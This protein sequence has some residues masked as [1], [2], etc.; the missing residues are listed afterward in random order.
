MQSKEIDCAQFFFYLGKCIV[1]L[2]VAKI[3]FELH[4]LKSLFIKFSLLKLMHPYM[5]AT[6]YLNPGLCLLTVVKTFWWLQRM[7]LE[8]YL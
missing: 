8:H 5:N 7:A 2:M 6:F 4:F 3:S 1:R